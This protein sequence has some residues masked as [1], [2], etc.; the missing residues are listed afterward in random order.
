LAECKATLSEDGIFKERF[1]STIQKDKPRSALT[2]VTQFSISTQL[3]APQI[4]A[5]K[6]T[7]AIKLF[8]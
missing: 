8:K 2:T 7:K 4:T 3:S 1:D 6:V 5:Q